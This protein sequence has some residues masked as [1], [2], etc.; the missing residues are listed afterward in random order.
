MFDYNG[1]EYVTSSHA[2]SSKT[3]TKDLTELGSQFLPEDSIAFVREIEGFLKKA[4][5]S[6]YGYTICLSPKKS[7]Y[8]HYDVDGIKLYTAYLRTTVARPA[9]LAV[10]KKASKKGFRIMFELVGGCMYNTVSRLYGTLGIEEVVDWRHKKED[11]FFHGI[12]KVPQFDV[13]G[14]KRK[15]F[16][17]SCD[18]CL[19]EVVKTMGF[20]RALVRKP[21]GYT[22]LITDPDGDR[23]V[24]GQMEPKTRETKL[25][26]LGVAVIPINSSKIFA[27]YHPTHSFLALMDF[28]MQMLKRAGVW[29]KHP[30]VF[31][32]TTPSSHSWI[33]WAKQNGLSVV[34][35][36]VG[37]K[38]LALIIRK[39]EKQLTEN[40]N[41]EVVVQDIF[42]EKIN[43]GKSPRLF[44]AGEESG[45][46]I[47]GP[48]ELIMSRGGRIAI[49]MH[50]KSAG[51]MS[52]TAIWFSAHLF[53][54]KKFI[55]EYIEEIYAQYGIQHCFYVRD[56]IT[57]YNES[58]L[59][60]IV[61]QKTK[62]DGEIIRDRIDFF[63]V[64]IA[65]AK[66]E[67]IVNIENVRSIFGSA[68]PQLNFSCL[69]DI[70]F[71]G[72]ATF[73]L[74]ADMFIEIRKSGTDAK[75]RGYASGNDLVRV[76]NFLNSF[77]HYNGTVFSLYAKLISAKFRKQTPH[78]TRD[79]YKAYLSAG[80]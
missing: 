58:E 36:P 49:S 7:P 47:T 22:V 56:D 68:F 20:D 25:R 33:E 44:F 50:E 48:E 27:I 31:I 55:S 73:I 78:K 65:M 23:L 10:I 62:I 12:G 42:G 63:Y 15:F 69:Q 80:L 19:P 52:V 70:I 30:R 75:M 35:T 46:M 26:D 43:L 72:D 11:P 39:I 28:N 71:V 32:T 53:L 24:M 9:T 1:G 16:D 77:L 64:S 76:K 57:Y 4:Q 61:L 29:E 74:F 60:P 45:G 66:R 18:A 40:P 5:H 3:A 79:F 59:D 54:E 34:L 38:E 21:I 67:G 37:F 8:I 41:K 17:L 13:H 6:R 14:K 51:E 2:A